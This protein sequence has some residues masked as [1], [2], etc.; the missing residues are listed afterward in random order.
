M[1]L[2]E[3]IELLLREDASLEKLE[4][5]VKELNREVGEVL[6]SGEEYDKDFLFDLLSGMGMKLVGSGAYRSVYGFDDCDWVIKVSK[7]GLSGMRMNAEEVGIGRGEHGIGARDLF[8]RLYSW[9]SKSELPMWLVTERV[10]SLDDIDKHLSVEDMARVFPTF[11]SAMRKEIRE[12]ISVKGFANVLYRTFYDL[13]FGVRR[14]GGGSG[15]LSREEFY[16]AI[17]GNLRSGVE[18]MSD[19]EW[20]GDWKKIARACAYTRPGDTHKG[21]IG[22]SLGRDL[23]PDAIVILDYLL[24]K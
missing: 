11:W 12:V 15:V 4:S 18:N 7:S 16:E 24:V 13:S 21:N 1:I 2:R 14:N 17:R 22:I 5:V 9:D 19:I 8:T 23:G 6:R 10:V 20:G 3:Y